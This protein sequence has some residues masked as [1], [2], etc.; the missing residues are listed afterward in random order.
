MTL[1]DALEAT[2]DYRAGGSPKETQAAVDE[3][4]VARQNQA[5]LAQLQLMLAGT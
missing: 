2:R 5:S 3:S 4:A 1:L